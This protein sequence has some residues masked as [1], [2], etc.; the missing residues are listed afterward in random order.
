M[1][2]ELIISIAF[3][4]SFGSS[5]VISDD[6]GAGRPDNIPDA[7][8]PEPIETESSWWNELLQ[9]FGFESE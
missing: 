2:K 9:G 8:N 5:H 4:A 1:K 7:T 3:A 6:I